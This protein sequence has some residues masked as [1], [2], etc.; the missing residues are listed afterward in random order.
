LKRSSIQRLAAHCSGEE[1]CLPWADRL[2]PAERRRFREELELLLG[3]PELTGEPL[4]WPEVWEL[5]REYAGLAGWEGPLLDGAEAAEAKPYQVAMRAR[6]R[7]AVER[8]A[9]GV[10][11]AAWDLL[12]GF[13]ARYPTDTPR[14][15][16]GRLKKMG[17]RGVWQIDLPDGYRLRYFVEEERRTVHVVYLGPHPDGDADGRERTARAAVR[18]RRSGEHHDR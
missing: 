13:L 10:Q 4:D 6:E 17:N 16:R 5:L 11:R 3:E 18:R 2:A 12:D 7:R 14:L 9:P 8:A 15:E 1:C